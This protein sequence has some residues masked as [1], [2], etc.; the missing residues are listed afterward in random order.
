MADHLGCGL[1]IRHRLFPDYPVDDRHPGEQ[2][3][4]DDGRPAGL[5]HAAAGQAAMMVA[6]LAKIGV[7]LVL[8]PMDYPSHLSRMTRKNN[9]EGYFFSNDH[10]GPFSAIRKNFLTGQTWNL[11]IMSIPYVDKTW[12][13]TV[14]NPN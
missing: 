7:T 1:A 3:S 13:D 5:D 6:Y 4:A 11:H 8:D 14:E 2:I 9:S 10:G 12:Q